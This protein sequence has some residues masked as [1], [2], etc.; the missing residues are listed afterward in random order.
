MV[1]VFAGATNSIMLVDVTEN[2]GESA[3]VSERGDKI[4]YY[5][6]SCLSIGPNWR[7]SQ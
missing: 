4:C 2:S 3:V 6:L 5:K 7:I 1:I